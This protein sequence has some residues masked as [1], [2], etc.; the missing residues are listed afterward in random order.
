MAR[1]APALLR[2]AFLC[3]TD[4]GISV[5]KASR[6]AFRSHIKFNLAKQPQSLMF[7]SSLQ[8]LETCCQCTCSKDNAVALHLLIISDGLR[9][10][11]PRIRSNRRSRCSKGNLSLLT[12]LRVSHFLSQPTILTIQSSDFCISCGITV[13][14]L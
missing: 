12:G 6:K 5:D 14:M 4:L 11:F 13:E 7:L 9:F 3:P 10:C 8:S 2:D 1:H